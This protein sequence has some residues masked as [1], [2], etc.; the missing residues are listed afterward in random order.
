[1]W[2]K[3]RRAK[4]RKQ[5]REEELSKSRTKSGNST[6]RS[7]QNKEKDSSETPGSSE[8][9]DEVEVCVDD[10]V[11]EDCAN[12]SAAFSE[13]SFATSSEDEESENNIGYTKKEGLSEQT[14]PNQSREKN[15][16]APSSERERSPDSAKNLIQNRD[17]VNHDHTKEK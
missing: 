2:F 3:N 9:L 16:D 7:E 12:S 4:W 1:M 17:S 11:S 10:D 15:V 13:S 5:K 8:G 6:E 14:I